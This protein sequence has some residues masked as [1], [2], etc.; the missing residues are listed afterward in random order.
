M[1]MK[2]I[3]VFMVFIMATSMLIA[4]FCY[5]NEMVSG[6]VKSFDAKTGR[7]FMQTASQREST[8]SIPQTVTVYFLVK[9][10]DAEIAD[11]WRFLSDNLMKGT[12]VQLTL[13]GGVV[14]TIL[15]LEVP[16]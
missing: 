12:K 14:V 7:L 16:R 10:K 6:V 11:E 8:F 5:A 13:S 4:N 9:G 2:K 15:I 3:I 1:M